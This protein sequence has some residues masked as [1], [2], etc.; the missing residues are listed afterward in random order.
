M[1]SE[2]LSQAAKITSKGHEA[3]NTLVVELFMVYSGVYI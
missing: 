1:Y 3:N 2:E